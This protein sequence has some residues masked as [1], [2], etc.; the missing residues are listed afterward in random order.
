VQGIVI[1]L[2][3]VPMAACLPTS[4]ISFSFYGLSLMVQVCVAPNQHTLNGRNPFVV[5]AVV[6]VV[7]R[8][9]CVKYMLPGAMLDLLHMTFSHFAAMFERTH[10][11]A[12]LAQIT[13]TCVQHMLPST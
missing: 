4:R 5:V 11:R 12:A 8:L 2:Q 3:A 7:A 10:C 13:F 1:L 9:V 6:V